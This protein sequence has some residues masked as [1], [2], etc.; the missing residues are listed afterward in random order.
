MFNEQATYKGIH[1]HNATREELLWMLKDMRME[2]QSMMKFTDMKAW[3]EHL[4]AKR[5]VS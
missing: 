2:A 4:K 5:E 3:A 1:I